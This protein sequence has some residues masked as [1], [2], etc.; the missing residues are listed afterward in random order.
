[1]IL[2]SLLDKILRLFGTSE[3][4]V[5]WK[6]QRRRQ[7]RE[8][9]KKSRQN[10][11]RHLRYRHKLCEECGGIVDRQ[12]RECPYCGAHVAGWG[13]QFGSR[14]AQRI[15]PRAGAMTSVLLIVNGVIFFYIAFVTGELMSISTY[16]NIHFGA[17]YGPLMTANDEWWRLL[18]YNFLHVG[19]LIHIGFNLVALAIVGPIVEEFYGPARATIIYVMSGLFGGLASHLWMPIAVS[20][21]AS[22]AVMGL[23]GAGVVAG[24]LE[25]TVSG[26]VM[27][28]HLFRWVI[29]T[30]IFGLLVSGIDNAAHFGGLVAGGVFGAGLRL[31]PRRPKSRERMVIGALAIALAAACAASLVLVVWAGRDDPAVLT[32]NDVRRYWFEC[33]Q[34]LDEAAP[35]YRDLDT[36]EKCERVA[37]ANFFRDGWSTHL[38]ALLMRRAG[39]PERA[40]RMLAILGAHLGTQ[41]PGRVGLGFIHLARQMYNRAL[42]M[43]ESSP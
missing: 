28:N 17:N 3:Q 20:G 8:Q 2:L 26:R 22:G 10:I 30:A 6:L 34:A 14:L 7:R 4:Q 27:R 35:A 15:V 33:R 18:S 43:P 41:E 36:A 23:V 12:A 19:G 38:A 37:R 40:D 29:Y 5:R 21:G 13:V 9:R 11:D 31:G 24:H 25:G 1:M 42:D 39:R 16:S 32:E